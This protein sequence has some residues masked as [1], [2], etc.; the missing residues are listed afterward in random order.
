MG[1]NEFMAMLAVLVCLIL[2]RLWIHQRH[3]TDLLIEG[4]EESRA[5][6]RL[7]VFLARGCGLGLLPKAPGTWGSLGG[8]A[9][10]ALLLAPG[11]FWFYLTGT[12]LGLAAS[13]VLCGRAAELIGQKDP[14]E[15]VLDEIAAFPACYAGL[16]SILNHSPSGPPTLL[17][18]AVQPN[19]WAWLVAGFL[20]FRLFDIWKPPPIRQIQALPGGW[21]ITAD[22]A[23]A[24]C[25]TVAILH[26]AWVLI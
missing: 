13:V 2:W 21:G 6:D 8:V 15:I 10:T 11:N 22:D 25:F 23:L 17:D 5:N 3:W 18:L 19:A 24:A 12:V 1:P 16:L 7:T 14:S 26:V 4:A 9:W 20:L